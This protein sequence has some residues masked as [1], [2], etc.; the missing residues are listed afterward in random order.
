MLELGTFKFTA[1][2]LTI[3]K[4]VV[5]IGLVG[6]LR[7][8]GRGGERAGGRRGSGDEGG[9]GRRDGVFGGGLLAVSL[10]F[11]QATCIT[12]CFFA[13]GQVHLKENTE[14]AL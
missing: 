14:V 9:G 12:S 6:V 7:G 13:S 8:W 3:T 10:V 2:S 1:D 5:P 4:R 11:K